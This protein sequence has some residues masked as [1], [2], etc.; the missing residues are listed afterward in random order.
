MTLKFF[1]T[2]ILL[3]KRQKQQFTGIQSEMSKKG[4][5]Y[6]FKRLTKEHDKYVE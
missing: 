6:F 3:F 1:P 4:I 5:V 2:E